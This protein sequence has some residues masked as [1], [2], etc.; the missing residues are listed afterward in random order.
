MVVARLGGVIQFPP[1]DENGS[2]NVWIGSSGYGYQSIPF[3]RGFRSPQFAN[4]QLSDLVSEWH[5][6]NRT[7][8]AAVDRAAIDASLADF[9]AKTKFADL[10]ILDDWFA[11]TQQNGIYVNRYGGAYK[12]FDIDVSDYGDQLRRV[13]GWVD[14]AGASWIALKADSKVKQAIGL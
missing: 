11:R 12:I 1:P 5:S 9:A 14:A 13:H 2:A 3:K 8:I 10:D 6:A 4:D 7:A